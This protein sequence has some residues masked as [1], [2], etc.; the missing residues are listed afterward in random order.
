VVRFENPGRPS[1]PAIPGG[2]SPGDGPQA[3]IHSG[4]ES[5]LGWHPW[6][7]LCHESE[8]EP[9]RFSSP[10]SLMDG[11]VLAKALRR[12]SR[13]F[14]ERVSAANER[15]FENKF[16]MGQRLGLQLLRGKRGGTNG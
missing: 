10:L 14:F 16:L 11:I 7:A 6:V 12:P 3:A 4:L 5:A 13:T 9:P 15:A 1:P 8:G 2:G